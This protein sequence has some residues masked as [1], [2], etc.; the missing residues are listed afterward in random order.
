MTSKPLTA[1]AVNQFS[2]PVIIWRDFQHQ[3]GTLMLVGLVLLSA[4]GVIY[5]A[6]YKRHLTAEYEQL[7]KEQDR[8]EVEWRNARLEMNA[9]AAHSRVEQIAR[10][11]LQMQSPA[12]NY[13]VVVAK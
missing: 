11:K 6:H 3:V 9:L 12:D 13:E 5:N 4:F 2:L 1:S 8:L 10:K 7:L